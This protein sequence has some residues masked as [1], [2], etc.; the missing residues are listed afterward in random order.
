VATVAVATVPRDGV[1]HRSG[2][3]A[4]ATGGDDREAVDVGAYHIGGVALVG[5]GG[6]LEQNGELRGQA[7]SGH[8]AGVVHRAGVREE[9]WCVQDGTDRGSALQN[10]AQWIE[11]GVRTFSCDKRLV[12]AK[13]CEVSALNVVPKRRPHDLFDSHGR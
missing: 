3:R 7:Q 10:F 12:L 11:R 6:G 9:G 5:E 4:V 13:S 2:G 1:R 8:H